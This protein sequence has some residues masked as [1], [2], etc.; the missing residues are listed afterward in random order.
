M[1]DAISK[2]HSKIGSLQ[3]KEFWMDTDVHQAWL[4]NEAR[5]QLSFFRKCLRPQGGFYQLDATGRPL[6]NDEQELF[7]TTRMVHSYSLGALH[8]FDECED[9]V[10]HGMNFLLNYHHDQQF[11]GFVWSLRDNEIHDGKKLA[12]GHAFVLLAASSAKQA[13]HP[14]ADTLL[15]T[16]TEVLLERFWN[17]D[18]GVFADE[19]NR[20]W[21][22]FSTYRGFNANMHSTEALLAAFEATQEE[23]YL[24]MAGRILDFFV[25]K[26][27]TS[28]NHRVPEHYNA[29]WSVDRNYAGDPMFRPAGTTPGHSLE[30]ARLLLQH[31]DLTGR[32][33][34]SIPRI[35]R[36][37]VN[38]AVADAWDT[39][40]GGFY[41]TLNLEGAPDVRS[42]YWWPVTEAIGVFAVLIKLDREQS[43][44]LWYR[45]MWQFADEFFIDH[46]QGG[47]YPEIDNLGRH[48]DLQFAGK[49][50]IYHSI[51]AAVFPMSKKI[52][53]L[54]AA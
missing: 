31:W 34:S 32:S 28:N 25:H 24:E 38:R 52:S 20:D 6:P 9:V 5:R 19:A 10:D 54:Y 21:T 7:A 36:N 42:R 15:E 14:D 2:Q 50:D 44:E 27:A 18:R 4:R 40:N 45:R 13:G 30:L 48:T 43:D 46:V 23:L 41:Y 47:W 37:L 53:D 17:E 11:G 49:P 51:Q 3:S 12:Y 16:I 33:N 39:E 22:P 29:D 8:G 1:D 26:V 35:A